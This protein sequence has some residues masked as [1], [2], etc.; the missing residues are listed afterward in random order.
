MRV[1]GRSLRPS[2]LAERRLFKS[3]G[4]DFL[5]VPRSMNPYA[6]ARKLSRMAAGGEDMGLLTKLAHRPQP[7]IW[8]IPQPDLDAPEPAR[9]WVMP[10]PS[11]A[12]A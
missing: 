6:V 8:T 9:P 12:A 2:N 10:S 7:N 11:H 4:A 5:R 3:V 1:N